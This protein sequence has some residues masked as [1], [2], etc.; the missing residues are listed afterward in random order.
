MSSNPALKDSLYFHTIFQN[1]QPQK[2]SALLVDGLEK[3]VDKIGR[4]DNKAIIS[5]RQ[6][7]DNIDHYLKNFSFLGLP[8]FAAHKLKQNSANFTAVKEHQLILQKRKTKIVLISL[9]YSVLAQLPANNLQRK[10][11]HISHTHD[12]VYCERNFIA[13]WRFAQTLLRFAWGVAEAKCT[14]VTAVCVF[15][16]VS[17]CQSPHSHT[18]ARTRM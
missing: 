1:N 3:S 13:A 4:L 7:V 18:T 8:H 6:S 10:I 5:K 16:C 17:V 15:V 12:E 11:H 2:T 9:Q 14:V